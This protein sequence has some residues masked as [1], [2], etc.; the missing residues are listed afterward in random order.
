MLGITFMSTG[1]FYQTAY[2]QSNKGSIIGTIKDPNDAVVPE[3]KVIVTN[4]ANGESIEV[5]SS[6]EGDFTVTNLDPGNYK[7]TIESSGFKTLVLSSVTV[8]TNSRVPV[9]IKF[10]DVSGVGD[11]IVTI[12]AD[13][14]PLVESETSARGDVITGREVTDLPIGQRNFTVLAGLSPGVTRP[15]GSSFGLL[16]G[17][18]EAN[19]PNFPSAETARFR[20]SGGSALSSNGARIT[21]N[22]FLLDGVDNNEAQFQTDCDLSKS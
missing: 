22:E 20:E 16:G 15:T 5:T 21:Q 6:S 10:T 4:N 13:S 11:N 9:D 17:G 3:A 19:Q 2:S 1:L 18:N 14:S 8:E 7:I 12:T